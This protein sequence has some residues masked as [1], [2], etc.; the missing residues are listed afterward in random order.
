MKTEI[1]IPIR[2]QDYRKTGASFSS[3]LAYPYRAAFFLRASQS[4]ML[5]TLSAFLNP[6]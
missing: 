1:E 2:E 3:F 4:G 5:R 6:F